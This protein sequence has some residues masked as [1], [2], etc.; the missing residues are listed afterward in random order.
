MYSS[1]QYIFYILLA[2]TVGTSIS[3]YYYYKVSKYKYP[4]KTTLI[5]FINR[6][7]LIST[8]IFLVL[9]PR[10]AINLTSKIKPQIVVAVDNTE[11]V[12]ILN[13][14]VKLKTNLV[15]LENQIE[16]LSKVFDVQKITFGEK[17]CDTCPLTHTE[18]E[19]NLSSVFDYIDYNYQQNRPKALVIVTDGVVNTGSLPTAK[20][21]KLDIPI[22]SIV[23][24]D[25]A[26]TDD[27]WIAS[28]RNNPVVYSN[29]RFQVEI[30]LRRTDTKAL[31]TELEIYNQGKQIAKL[32]VEFMADEQRVKVTPM[33]KANKPGIEQYE[34]KL[35]KA[36]TE[37]N[38]ENNRAFFA[39]EVIDIETNILLLYNAPTPDIGLL[40]RTIAQNKSINLDIQHVDSFLGDFK[41]Y[42][43]VIFM[44]IP[45]GDI[46]A[47]RYVVEAI[48]QNKPSWFFIGSKTNV[49]MLSQLNLGWNM[50]RMGKKLD[51][52]FATENKLYNYFILPLQLQYVLD[53]LPPLYTQFGKW[54]INN[55]TE[56]ALYQQVG[57]IKTDNPLLLTTIHG[58]RRIAIFTGEGLWRWSMFLDK[59]YGSASAVD[60]LINLVLQFL[61][62]KTEASPLK[63]NVQ[64]VW[65]K[66]A[67]VFIDAYVYNINYQLINDKKVELFLTKEENQHEHL[68]MQPHGKHY[69]TYIGA[70]PT[71]TYTVM[72][73][74]Q[75]DTATYTEN[76]I[77][78][79]ADL[80]LEKQ[81]SQPDIQLMR[82]ISGNDSARILFNTDLNKISDLIIKTADSRQLYITTSTISDIIT[83]TSLLF[84]VTICATIEWLI[85]KYHGQF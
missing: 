31:S 1:L 38:N 65:T 17:I 72:A 27:Y 10:I 43:A 12:Q 33:I 4:P 28:I 8:L 21:S 42:T 15:T 29:N 63:I 69:R 49:S 6:T 20:A 19:T 52:V 13:D 74:Y 73:Q 55:K 54:N 9:N 60:D 79:V 18:E 59:N 34:V 46:N 5:L 30:E 2:L 40:R 7:V 80:N 48:K 47:D 26:I 39:V 64:P 58:N 61:S 41:P 11:S 53:K 62:V 35:N 68:T 16:Q 70:L 3:Y 22:Y 66:T 82:D 77:F 84:I 32:P 45:D 36:A 78:T 25:T 76:K 75:T 44:H 56:I 24:A 85:R 37:I 50:T 71:G 67:N 23:F 51:M 83:I 57:D 14:T 81:V